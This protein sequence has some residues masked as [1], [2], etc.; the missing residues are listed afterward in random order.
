MKA[1]GIRRDGYNTII[2]ITTEANFM[3]HDIIL[4]YTPYI[5]YTIIIYL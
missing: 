4:L 2:Y 1:D 3:P 5:Y